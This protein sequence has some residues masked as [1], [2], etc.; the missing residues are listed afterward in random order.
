MANYLI[1]K[2]QSTAKE[3]ITNYTSGETKVE[4]SGSNSLP[5]LQ[6][7]ISTFLQYTSGVQK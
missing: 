6:V 5:V 3:K 1:T 4:S 7:Y 2:L